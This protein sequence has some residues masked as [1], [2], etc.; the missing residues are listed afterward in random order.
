MACKLYSEKS[1]YSLYGQKN[2]CLTSFTFRENYIPLEITPLHCFYLN[3]VKTA[4]KRTHLS[5]AIP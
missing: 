1:F 2:V 4:I 3:D 5:A